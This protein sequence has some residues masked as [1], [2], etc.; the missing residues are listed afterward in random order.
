MISSLQTNIWQLLGVCHC[1]LLNETCEN[2]YHSKLNRLVWQEHFLHDRVHTESHQ[3][4][5]K[6]CQPLPT[7]S[8]RTKSSRGL[9]AFFQETDKPDVCNWVSALTPK[10]WSGLLSPCNTSSM[11]KRRILLT[12]DSL[13]RVMLNHW[14]VLSSRCKYFILCSPRPVIILP[15]FFHVLNKLRQENFSIT[16]F[17]LNNMI[18]TPRAM[19]VNFAGG[20]PKPATFLTF[21]RIDSLIVGILL[22]NQDTK[23]WDIS[24]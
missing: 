20:E 16:F 23:E 8:W 1:T 15:N 9:C 11:V 7:C 6:V 17:V 14:S 24:L 10:L 12:Y 22:S 4:K 2:Y 21:A 18:V 3:E 13:L 5:Y 19:G